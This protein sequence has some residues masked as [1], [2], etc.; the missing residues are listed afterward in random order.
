M[1]KGF[2]GV[3]YGDGIGVMLK[4][5]QEEKVMR[6]RTK[7]LVIV[8]VFLLLMLLMTGCV[9][10]ENIVEEII[11][12][13][14]GYYTIKEVTLPS[15]QQSVILPVGGSISTVASPIMFGERV[16]C[17]SSVYDVE[18]NIQNF[19]LQI[20]DAGVGEWKN[21]DVLQSSFELDGI[22]YDGIN[23]IITSSIDERIYTQA[24][25]ANQANYLVELESGSVTEIICEVPAEFN[26]KYDSMKDDL[27]RDWDGNFYVFSKNNN[28]IQCYDHVLQNAKAEEVPETNAVY[29]LVQSNAGADVY[30]YGMNLEGKPVIGDM[31]KGTVVVNGLEGIGTD[32]VAGVSL[33]QTFYLAD[34]QNLWKVMD[35]KVYKA[36]RF[37]ANGYLLSEV[38]GIKV[39]DEREVL[40][41][42]KM[43]GELTFLHMK[44]LDEPLEKQEI[45]I[46]FTMQHLALNKS[47]ARFNRQN[48]KYY[49]SVM[50]PEEGEE[51]D[52]FRRRVQLEIS[53]GKGPDILGHDMVLDFSSYVE[54]G[55]L[56]CVD[57]VFS[58]PSLYLKAALEDAKINGHFFSVPY[59]CTFDV[60]AYPT[61]N[62]GERTSWT[63][64]ELMQAVENSDAVILQENLDGVSIIY[65]YALK[66][67]SN[68]TFIDWKAG[69]SHL[70]EQ[71]FVD[72]LAFAKTYEDN[73]NGEKKAFAKTII[74][75]NDLRRI[76][77][78][79]Q[80]GE[81]GVAFLGYPREEGNGIYVNTRALYLNANP[82]CKEGAITF[83]EFLLSEEEQLKYVTYDS[84]EQM[85]EEGLKTL[86]GHS[87]QFPV[88]LMAYD[89]MVDMELKGDMDNLVYTDSGIIQLDIL[90]TDE[91]IEQFNFILEHAQP[92][93]FYAEAIYNIVAEELV[94][95]FSGDISAQEAAKKLDSR[96]QL[97]LDEQN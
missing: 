84:V 90:Y 71:S 68:T 18:Y 79:Y 88:S 29:G 5:R 27:T 41:L 75:F 54:N 19:F 38:Y 50:L 52:A 55:Y 76:K 28:V 12:G 1:F 82:E 69:E 61:E 26:E 94:P 11:V 51:E 77:E 78:V 87:K 31:T 36:F 37:A 93:N 46:A 64:Q 8:S 47:I 25:I 92:S 15:P 33:N 16:F 43:D 2:L 95:Y 22:Q 14:E 73:G 23:S 6:K 9:K 58:E 59:D 63:L 60:I 85:R 13:Q 21:M 40:L 44:E 86:A 39:V 20:W 53:A 45:V 83:F 7:R 17:A 81:T 97:Y 48:D 72:L 24:Y 3:L 32:C 74:S 65:K 67:N 66:D 96:V 42:V 10:E 57:E 89:K 34:T 80:S 4:K 49:I 35:G 70:D 62:I 56:E 91:M 30:W